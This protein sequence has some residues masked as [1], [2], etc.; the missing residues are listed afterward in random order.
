[1]RIGDAVIVRT[2]RGDDPHEGQTGQL[3]GHGPVSPGLFPRPLTWHVF[4]CGRVLHYFETELQPVRA[5]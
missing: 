4:L 3:V 2:R 1:M 5:Q